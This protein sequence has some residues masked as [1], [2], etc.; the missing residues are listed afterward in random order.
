MSLRTV[1]FRVAEE[2]LLALDAFAKLQQR[3]R[4]FVLNEAVSQFLSLHA[5]HRQLIERG[6]EEDEAG[7]V[8][9]HSEVR[10]LAAE[11][12]QQREP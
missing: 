7:N 4:S 8:L 2:Q 12:T 1:T 3:D 11:W 5:Y 9:G 10:R 6:I